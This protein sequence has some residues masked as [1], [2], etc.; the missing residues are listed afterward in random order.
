MLNKVFLRARS[1]D[2]LPFAHVSRPLL[3][4]A[5]WRGGR[6]R[7]V[8][9]RQ[10]FLKNAVFAVSS[11]CYTYYPYIYPTRAISGLI[12]ENV[13]RFFLLK[14]KTMNSASE[15][16]RER[17]GGEGGEERRGCAIMAKTREWK[18]HK[19]GLIL[20]RMY[21]DVMMGSIRSNA[22]SSCTAFAP[23]VHEEEN[24]KF[25]LRVHILI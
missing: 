16:E 22:F 5:T 20:I 12:F 21:V 8:R 15:R 11:L 10:W 6:A 13:Q 18:F 9:Y 19:S 4:L 7:C 24:K 14:Y 1:I 23:R 2:D 25:P 3:L 17:E